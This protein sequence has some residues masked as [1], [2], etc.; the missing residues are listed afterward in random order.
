MKIV[1]YRLESLVLWLSVLRRA[2][3]LAPNLLES[4]FSLGRSN[5]MPTICPA[6]TT[7]NLFTSAAVA[8]VEL[9]LKERLLALLAKLVNCLPAIK[10]GDI[11]NCGKIV[12]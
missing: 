2:Q 9:V 1:S 11:V 8:R 5:E 3:Y 6:P 12:V 7:P 10:G 4:V